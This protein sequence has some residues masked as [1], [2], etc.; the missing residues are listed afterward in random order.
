MDEKKKKE[1]EEIKIDKTIFRVKR[2]FGSDSLDKILTDW[3]V[4]K[5][6]K[7]AMNFV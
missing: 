2:R 6:L 3:A 7:S 5:A 4:Q 1:Y